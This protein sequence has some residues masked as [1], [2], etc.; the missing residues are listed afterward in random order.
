MVVPCLSL[1]TNSP[2]GG[3]TDGGRFGRP[4]SCWS[5][6]TSL[7]F[8]LGAGSRAVVGRCR[9]G[10]GR[11]CPWDPTSVLEILREV[12]KQRA[13]PVS[14]VVR[15]WW[16]L[17]QGQCAFGEGTAKRAG[18]GQICC[19]P[20]LQICSG[21]SVHEQGFP[22]GRSFE[23]DSNEGDK[24]LQV[25]GRQQSGTWLL[26]PV[27][28]SLKSYSENWLQALAGAWLVPHRLTDGSALTHSQ[29]RGSRHPP[30]CLC[31]A[32]WRRRFGKSW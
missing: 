31:T 22:W 26:A 18:R 25:M 10:D 23:G 8:M 1:I 24:S 19:S 5:S 12:L 28:R 9:G 2:F 11:S 17:C 20:S 27:S 13:S 4:A 29:P 21:R 30:C 14:A 6:G 7:R 32:W 15:S 3:C 16:R